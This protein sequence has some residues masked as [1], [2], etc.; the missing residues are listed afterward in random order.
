MPLQAV[1]F[2]FMVHGEQ[3]AIA[4]LMLSGAP[5]MRTNSK[6][7]HYRLGGLAR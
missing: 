6:S 2:E 3:R 1:S 4:I 7:P 5:R